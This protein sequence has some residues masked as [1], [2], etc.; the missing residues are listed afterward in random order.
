[1][2]DLHELNE[3]NKK[4]KI[5]QKLAGELA[6]GAEFI[7]ALKKNMSRILASLKMLELNISDAVDLLD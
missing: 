5:M 6:D 1:M 3:I 2:K 7:P 4:I